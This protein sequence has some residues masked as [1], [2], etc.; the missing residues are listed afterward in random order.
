VMLPERLVPMDVSFDIHKRVEMERRSFDEPPHVALRRLLGLPEVQPS[1][2]NE[3]AP[4]ADGKPW[5][6]GHVE[7]P[8]GSDARMSYGRGK[9]EFAGKF[10]DGKLVV[11][12]R[13]FNTLSEAASSLAVT[14]YGDHP[15]LNGWNYWEVRFPGETEWRSMTKMRQEARKRFSKGIR[16]SL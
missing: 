2:E 14:K 13:S 10:L 15:S 12:G 4:V 16:I 7:V 6:D 1:A 5:R 11:E 9:Q 8:H 3:N